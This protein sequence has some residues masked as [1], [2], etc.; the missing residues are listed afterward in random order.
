MVITVELE[1]LR[2]PF[3]VVSG[4]IEVDGELAAEGQL[5]FAAVEAE[6]LS[7]RAPAPP[8]GNPTAEIQNQK[9]AAAGLA[10]GAAG[11]EKV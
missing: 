3:A 6:L 7:A 9:S 4:K 11:G 8:A 5:R 2:G 10:D 1:R